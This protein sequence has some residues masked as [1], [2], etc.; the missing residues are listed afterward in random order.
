MGNS[1]RPKLKGKAASPA[2]YKTGESIRVGTNS[3]KNALG[4]L[5]SAWPILGGVTILGVGLIWFMRSA[6]KVY[7][8]PILK[9]STPAFGQGAQAS[10][11][12]NATNELIKVNQILEAR[13]PV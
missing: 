8:Q 13:H 3:D 9:L 5:G 7:T 11:I 10:H 6:D 1:F 2:F 12:M 4:P